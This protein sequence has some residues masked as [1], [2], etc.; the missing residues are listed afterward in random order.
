MPAPSELATRL[1]EDLVEVGKMFGFEAEK[2]QPIK[3]GSK[4]R[5][6]VFWKMK[7]PEESPF[8]DIN[9]ASIEIQYS[10]APTSISHGILK[11]EKT[12]HPAIHFVISYFKLTDDYKENVLKTNYPRSGLVIID[13]EDDF[14]KLNLWITRFV[15]IKEEEKKLAEK[16]KKI[17]KF[18]IS[19][20][21]SID[22]SEMKERIRKNFQSEIEE[23]FLPP[24]ISSLIEAFVEIESKGLGDR[25]I[26]D[27]VF[28]KFIEFVQS[29]IEKYNIPRI[30]V[31]ANF[32]FSE[33]NI[34]PAVSGFTFNRYIEI[35]R[36]KVVIRDSEGEGTFNVYVSSGNAYIASEVIGI[37]CEEGLY[38]EDFLDFLKKAS[39]EV[40]S[41]IRKFSIS[42]EDRKLLKA[43]TKALS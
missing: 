31:R 25:K 21:P 3:E 8:P 20:S 10:Y 4:F 19:Q 24:E 7:M 6:D 37:L 41:Q 28:N 22:E 40:E 9:V 2:E 26:I 16:G 14:R 30:Y 18:A 27:D 39:Q 33:D 35:E 34:A 43:I 12:L 13:G 5:V 32:L 23:V 1:A 29:K 11:A 36:E 17:R 38:V 15:T 42:D